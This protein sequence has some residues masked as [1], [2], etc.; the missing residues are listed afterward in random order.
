MAKFFSMK[1]YPGVTYYE[2]SKKRFN[3]KPDKC[4]YIR[5]VDP[6]GKRIREKIGWESEG[7]TA[8]YAF[9]IRNER[10]RDIRLGE[11]VIPIQ[12][13]KKQ[14]ITFDEFMNEK[15]LPYSKD[16]KN[17]SSYKREYQLYNAWIKPIIGEKTLKDISP[18]DLEKIKKE[19]KEEGKAPRTIEYALAVVRQAFNMAINWGI[20]SGINPV[21]KVKKPKE[22][23]KRIRFLSPEEAANLLEELKKHSKQTYE[24]AYLSLYTGM[25]AGEIF[26]LRW[27]DIDFDNGIIYIKNSKNKTDRVAYMTDGV[28][29]MLLDKKRNLKEESGIVFKSSKGE[30][31]TKI[32][33]SF[34]R[35]VNALGL[36]DNIVDRKDRVVFHTLRHTFASWLAIKGTPI[37]TIKELMGHKTLAMTERYSHLI[38]DIKRKAV[39]NLENVSRDLNS[40]DKIN[41]N[42]SS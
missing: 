41:P 4:Y 24:M 12:K 20:Y 23:N 21:A 28:K 34:F 13:K 40:E 36:N 16:N 39:E 30:K 26:N 2:S 3:G 42:R 15:Y 25:R 11:E 38:P 1:K 8:K 33:H 31:I 6:S 27:E 19:M 29:E 10:L 17:S 35:A 9:E 14:K 18:F 37:Y 7:V 5:Y 22:D 32:S